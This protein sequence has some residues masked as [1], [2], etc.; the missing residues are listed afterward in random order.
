MGS[1]G[2]AFLK[3]HRNESNPDVI[4]S[5][6]QEAEEAANFIRDFVVQS[7]QNKAGNYRNASCRHSL[8]RQHGLGIRLTSKQIETMQESSMD[9]TDISSL[10]LPPKPNP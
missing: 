4:Q 5:R 1:L 7:V 10:D 2:N 3:A 6:L 8:T 9:L